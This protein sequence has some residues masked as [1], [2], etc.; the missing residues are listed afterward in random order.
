MRGSKLLWAR[1]GK[2]SE[3]DR[4]S[5]LEERHT[6]DAQNQQRCV[7]CG[8]R[9]FLIGLRGLPFRPHSVLA[10]VQRL[11]LMCLEL[12][13]DNWLC[14]GDIEGLELRATGFTDADYGMA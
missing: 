1:T 11:A 12:A 14:L 4:T 8:G 13:V 7:D 2:G 3:Q 6:G 5:V 9:Y 10:G